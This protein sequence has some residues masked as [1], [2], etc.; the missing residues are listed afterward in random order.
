MELHHTSDV[1]EYAHAVVGFLEAEPCSRNILRG[2]IEGARQG[3]PGWTAPPGFWW[4]T[5]DGVVA[6]AVSW[7]PPYG[8]LVS[9]M[10][11]AVADE[12]VESVRARG[13]QLKIMP[14]SV[15]GPR[16]AAETVAAAWRRVIG[17]A[18][19]IDL[20]QLLH[21]LDTLTEPPRPKGAW[22]R[23]GAGDVDLC[24]RWLEVFAAEAGVIAG[25]DPH[26][27]VE[28]LAAAGRLFLWDAGGVT[29][30]MVAHSP[31]V[32]GVARVG[33]VY[34][35]AE[36]RQRGYARRL[37]YE[38]TREALAIPGV[39]RVMLYTDVANP[40]SNSI[41]RQIGYRPVEEHLQ[42]RLVS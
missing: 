5:D 39:T 17:G 29:A 33:P 32:V 23:A 2:V 25:A 38:A 18:A 1:E 6:G 24:A 7:T 26:G 37:T 12:L 15:N 13:Q 31:P 16:D 41:Y 27:I 34:T 8:L 20:S 28:R 11:A 4:V 22:R 30:S 35:P 19:T 9:A 21:V 40:T 42:M 3:A 36:H 14:P 10:P